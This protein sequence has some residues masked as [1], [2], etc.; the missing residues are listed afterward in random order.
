MD[1]Y[2]RGAECRVTVRAEWLRPVSSVL[3]HDTV[4]PLGER[5]CAQPGCRDA[6]GHAKRFAIATRTEQ[7]CSR[8]SC[9]GRSCS[10]ATESAHL[11]AADS[12][13]DPQ[14]RTRRGLGTGR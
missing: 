6:A 2:Q 11:L 12:V 9:K 8:K 5:P 14:Y 7:P 13:R 4:G 10:R 1:S 3:A